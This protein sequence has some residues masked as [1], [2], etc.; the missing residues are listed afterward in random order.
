MISGEPLFYEGIIQTNSPDV[1]RG[2]L[3]EVKEP[4]EVE[5][6]VEEEHDEAEEKPS[7]FKKLL[8]AIFSN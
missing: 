7:F 3:I 8:S 5:N 1:K 4:G 6:D 2:M